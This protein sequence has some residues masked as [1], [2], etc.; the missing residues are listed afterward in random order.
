MKDAETKRIRA[1]ATWPRPDGGAAGGDLW[2]K[3]H[4]F[5]GEN[6]KAYQKSICGGVSIAHS[7]AILTSITTT[8][9]VSPNGMMRRELSEDG[10][11]PSAASCRIMASIFKVQLRRKMH[12]NE[13][14][15]MIEESE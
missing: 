1:V 2:T 11:H 14:V 9:F 5:S 7:A 3:A 13:V 4:F 10:I 12:Q 6:H 15:Q 8:S